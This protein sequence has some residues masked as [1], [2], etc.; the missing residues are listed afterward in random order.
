MAASASD[1]DRG[2]EATGVYWKPVLYALEEVMEV[3]L[4]NAAQV[5]QV[6]GRKTEVT[7]C[8]WLAQLLEHGLLRA[9]FIPPKPIR[10][11]RDLTRYRKRLSDEH[12]RVAN[13][14]EKFWASAA[15][16][17]WPPITP[18]SSRIEPSL[19]CGRAF[20]TWET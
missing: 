7:D 17:F 6:P 4:V 11:L 20:W 13:R 2:E 12:S 8:G 10:E 14:L 16:R 3:M 19:I 5:K 15:V 9:S 18:F 1:T